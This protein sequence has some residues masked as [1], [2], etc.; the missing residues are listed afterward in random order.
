MKSPAEL[1]AVVRQL[2]RRV[3]VIADPEMEQSL[4]G[5]ALEFSLLAEAIERGLANGSQAMHAT[6]RRLGDLLDDGRVEPKTRIII[7]A[8]LDEYREMIKE[9][10]R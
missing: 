10:E 5:Q 2:H 4:A 9:A 7:G 6:V 1:R 3:A 8:I